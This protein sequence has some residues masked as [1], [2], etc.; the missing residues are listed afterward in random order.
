MHCNLRLHTG[1]PYELR[2]GGMVR[3]L[4]SCCVTTN[5]SSSAYHLQ[6][7][8]TIQFKFV[9]NRGDRPRVAVKVVIVLPV[10]HSAS[11]LLL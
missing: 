7:C 4:K 5:S 10:H 3:A 11:L 6:I 8:V 1:F 2:T 9:E